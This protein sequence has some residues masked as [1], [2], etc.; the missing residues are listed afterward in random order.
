M[1]ATNTN[2]N[3]A[4]CENKQTFLTAAISDISGN[5]KYLDTKIA[6]VMATVGVFLG[7][8][9]SGV[10]ALFEMFAEQTMSLPTWIACVFNACMVLFGISVVLVFVFGILTITARH[11]KPAK[12]SLWYFD[13][14]TVCSTVFEEQVRILTDDL[15]VDNLAVELFYLNKINAQK[16]KFTKRTIKAFAFA[17]IFVALILSIV[18]FYILLI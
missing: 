5:I 17:S 11:T 6:L 14:A 13:D 8:V 12:P 16:M 10:V 15:I 7:V 1:E 3:L 2:N 18:G 4:S 9:V